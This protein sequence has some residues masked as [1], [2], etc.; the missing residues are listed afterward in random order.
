MADKPASRRRPPKVTT[1][2][3]FSSLPAGLA[4]GSQGQDAEPAMTRMTMAA[5]DSGAVPTDAAARSRLVALDLARSLALMCMVIFHLTYD[6][7]AF[8]LAPPGIVFTGGWPWFARGIATS[9]LLLAGLSLWLA[10]GRAIRWPAFWRRFAVLAAAAGLVSLATF[11]QMPSA[12]VRFGILHMI[13]AGSLIGLAFLRLPVTVTLGCAA[14]AFVAP[15]VLTTGTFD[16]PALLWLGLQSTVPPMID[17]EPLL[18]W[19]CPVLIGVALGRLFDRAG[20]WHRL[21]GWQ[22]GRLW[23]ALSWPGRHSLIIYL[24]HQP[25]L[26]GAIN[27]WILLFADLG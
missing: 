5:A 26:I 2:G 1:I 14:A 13:A 8:G 15:H 17:Y 25:L 24:I 16:H 20:T 10:H 27:L 21:A 12:Y 3:P 19:L 6:L 18:P 9:F 7:M 4:S 23:R 22:P 11:Y